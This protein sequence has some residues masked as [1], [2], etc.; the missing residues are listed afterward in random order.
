MKH[1]NKTAICGALGINSDVQK[2]CSVYTHF[3]MRNVSSFSFVIVSDGAT[4]S[5]YCVWP[6]TSE[7]I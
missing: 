5:G 2:I 4:E 1:V 6:N 3:M 7:N